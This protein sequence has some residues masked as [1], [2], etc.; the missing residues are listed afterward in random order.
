[1]EMSRGGLLRVILLVVAAFGLLVAVARRLEW[2]CDCRWTRGADA[3][4][5]GDLQ[6]V[7]SSIELYKIQHKQQLP[8]TV[9][10]V[11]FA[12]A[13][14]RGT[15]ACGSLNPGNPYGP[16]LTKIPANR[17]NGLDSVE[18]DGVLGGGNYGWHYDTTTGAF[19]ADTNQDTDL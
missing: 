6:T 16:Y 4:I 12:K 9:T 14:T 17:R 2:R 11:S 13:M 5:R 18:I 8:G 3:V 15:N 19:H 1:M 7:R 10:D